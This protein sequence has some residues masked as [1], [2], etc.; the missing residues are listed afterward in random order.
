MSLKIKIN[1][2]QK[3]LVAR[4]IIVDKTLQR[5]KKQKLKNKKQETK[6]TM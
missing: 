1:E 3:K 5:G 2:L 6:S 4:N